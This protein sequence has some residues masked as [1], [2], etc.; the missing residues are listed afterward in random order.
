MDT[1]AATVG[2]PPATISEQ[3]H[4]S[5]LLGQQNQGMVAERRHQSHKMQKNEGMLGEMPS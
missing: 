4:Q 2:L 5:G 3:K 1:G